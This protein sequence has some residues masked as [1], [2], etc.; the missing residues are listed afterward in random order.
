MNRDDETA[1]GR[2]EDG[3]PGERV[4][5][6]VALHGEIALRL[7]STGMERLLRSIVDATAALFDAEAASIALVEPDGR[8][9]FR[10]AAG[11]RSQGVVGM[12]VGSGEG[13]A[14]FVQVTGQ[15]IAVA[16]VRADPRFHL[17]AAR[18]TGYVPRTLL[19]V[20]LQAGDRVLGVL[21]ILDK[22]GGAG[23]DMHD[24]SL[25]GIF[26]R[27]AAVALDVTKVER[28]VVRLIEET[29]TRRQAAAMPAPADH[30]VA[31]VPDG[32]RHPLSEPEAGRE[33]W[34]LVDRLAALHAV[35]PDRLALLA[36]LLDVAVRHLAPARP[37]RR[38]PE[39]RPTWRDRA[40]LAED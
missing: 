14:G 4:L 37:A 15:P 5:D 26:A 2:R 7:E 24:I 25:A 3:P 34:D 36:D 32:G 28:D 20:P 22:R 19:A 39:E 13:I 10:V 38:R 1:G 23:F 17:D 16:D 12:V 18:R 33:F 35:E 11:A 6:G 9:R 40:H 31:E 30:Q 27:Q 21:E 29:A 8:L